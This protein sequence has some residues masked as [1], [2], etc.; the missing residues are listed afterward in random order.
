MV[1]K[2]SIHSIHFYPEAVIA[3]LYAKLETFFLLQS[4]PKAM[5]D[6]I[7]N[8]KL[9]RKYKKCAILSHLFLHLFRHAK[10]D[11][12]K[13]ASIIDNSSKSRGCVSGIL[14]SIQRLL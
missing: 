9:C 10:K 11:T 8:N 7:K 12:L 1:L 3:Q 2:C 13:T 14:A 6:G 5:E 4:Y